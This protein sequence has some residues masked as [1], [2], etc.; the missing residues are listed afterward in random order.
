MILD[1]EK[2]TMKKF[3]YTYKI[4]WTQMTHTDKIKKV[5]RVVVYFYLETRQMGKQLW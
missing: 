4:K 2:N 5:I 3:Y 1:L